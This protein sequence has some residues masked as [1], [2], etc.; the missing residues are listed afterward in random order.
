MSAM[1]VW[2]ILLRV[3]I[4]IVYINKILTS[5][6]ISICDQINFL[7]KFL[8][9]IVKVHGHIEDFFVGNRFYI[10]ELSMA[11]RFET[12]LSRWSRNFSLFPEMNERTKKNYFTLQVRECTDEKLTS[13]PFT[14]AVPMY[15]G[16][17]ILMYLA[18]CIDLFSS[19]SLPSIM[20]FPSF[21]FR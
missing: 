4:I 12:D 19:T 8:P 13:P 6:S 14:R 21:L 9:E 17:W 7:Q 11:V 20:S 5:L 18:F 3:M 1:S 16:S 2:M 15:N 10:L